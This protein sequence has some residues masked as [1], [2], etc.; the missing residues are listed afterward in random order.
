MTSFLSRVA[1]VVAAL[2]V[3]IGAAVVAG[4]AALIALHEL[5]RL[6]RDLRPLVLAGYGGA[7]GALLGAE[8]GGA[9]WML[10][11]F[12]VTFPLAFLFAAISATRQSS[13]VAIGS[14]VLGA[15]WVSLGLAHLILLRRLDVDGQDAILAVLLTVFAIDTFAYVGGR[16]A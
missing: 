7:L 2:P 12:L 15:A 5:Y 13:T 3:V 9:E 4:I 6:A 1:V 8:L 16:L 11:G 14:T 10:A